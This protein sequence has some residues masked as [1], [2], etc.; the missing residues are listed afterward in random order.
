[1]HERAA[2]RARIID[3]LSLQEAA[4]ACNVSLATIKRRLDRAR[5]SF[6]RLADEDAFLREMRL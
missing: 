3:G 1:M 6:H 4:D 2:F 5:A